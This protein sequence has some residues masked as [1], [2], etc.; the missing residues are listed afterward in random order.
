MPVNEAFITDNETIASLDNDQLKSTVNNHI[1]ISGNGAYYSSDLTN[2]LV[3]TSVFGETLN[4][5][6]TDGSVTVNGNN[7]L[8]LDILTS[9]GVV[10]RAK[11][12]S[13]SRGLER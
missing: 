1:V 2:G 10:S 3:L 4:I 7:A 8:I 12:M 9:N 13:I 11:G 5:S 6:V